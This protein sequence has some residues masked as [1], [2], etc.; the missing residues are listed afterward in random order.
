MK[1]VSDGLYEID[2]KEIALL[3]G[4]MISFAEHEAKGYMEKGNL[5]VVI[6]GMVLLDQI[7]KITL[8]HCVPPETAVELAAFQKFQSSNKDAVDG[9]ELDALFDLFKEAK[10]RK[11]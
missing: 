10:K 4:G 5:G 7:K 6:T 8:A 3:T 11:G 2:D 1:R 9:M